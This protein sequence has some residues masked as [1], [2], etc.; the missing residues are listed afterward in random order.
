MNSTPSF[1]YNFR[2]ESTSTEGQD[3]ELFALDRVAQYHLPDNSILAR[4][5]RNAREMVLPAEV[6]SAMTYCD[7]FRTMEEHVAHLME[8]NDESNEKQK[9]IASIVQ[10]IR[11]GGLTVSARDICAKLT[12]DEEGVSVQAMPVV[13]LITCERPK[14]L[15]R[16]L[17]SFL[18][19]CDLAQVRQCFIVDDSRSADNKSQNFDITRH[20]NSLVDIEISYFGDSEARSLVK[21]LIQRLPIYEEQIHFLI[22]PDRWKDYFSVGVARN[23]SLLLSV[24]NPVIVF[25]DDSI[26]TAYESPFI[27]SGLEFSARQR[28]AH[29]YKIQDE[30]HYLKATGDPDP[31]KQHMRCLGLPVSEALKVMGSGTPRQDSM[32]HARPEFAARLNRHSKI[33]VTECGSLGDPGTPNNKWLATIP[34]ESRKRLLKA[35]SQL[36]I[37]LRHRNCW[38]GVDRPTFKPS[39]NISQVSGFDNREFLPPYFPIERGEDRIFGETV[40]FIFPDSVCL[41]YPWATPHLP[42]PA[43]QWSQTDN[44]APPS[45]SFPGRLTVKTAA[46]KHLCQAEDPYLRLEYLAQ[47]FRDLANSSKASITNLHAENWLENKTARLSKLHTTLEQSTGAPQSWI[48]YLRHSI[49]NTQTAS[50]DVTDPPGVKGSANDLMGDDLIEFWQA[51][52]DGFGRALPAWPEIRREAKTIIDEQFPSAVIP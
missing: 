21:T 33:L 24:G 7:S 46:K 11:E 19:V 2:V 41:N 26:C 37:A 42:V 27:G 5:P 3:P 14:A 31:V 9:A 4:N 38:L 32:R 28:Q 52:W 29:F 25:D 20:Y 16:L 35:E 12:P 6:M 49:Q 13:V 39:A 8:G 43:R 45:T 15:Q 51:A 30:K 44:N 22:G 48:N 50:F 40:S 34:V 17:E 36:E 1:S 23:Y 10:S 18:A 47:L